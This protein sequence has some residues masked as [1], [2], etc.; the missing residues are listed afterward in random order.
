MG[1]ADLNLRVDLENMTNR[2]DNFERAAWTRDFNRNDS[3]GG[4]YHMYVVPSALFNAFFTAT[5]T[6]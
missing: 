3:L 6:M 2:T 5:V 4:Q 1:N